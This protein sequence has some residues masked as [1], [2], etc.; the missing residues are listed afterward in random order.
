MTL[1]REFYANAKEHRN[2][3]TK[4]CGIVVRFDEE[5]IN[6]HLGLV[7]PKEDDL[8]N[9][10]KTADMQKVM[11]TI[12]FKRTEWNISNGAHATFDSKYLE[13][14]M[15]VWFNF[16]NARL[17]PTTHVS[18]CSRER[19]L[20]LF[21]IATGMRMN[22][23]AIINAAILH[24]ANINNVAFP[25]PS[26]LT[27]LFEKAGINTADNAICRPI[28]ALDPNGIVRNWNNQS[29]DR[30]DEAEPSRASTRR[31]S[32]ASISDLHE[33]YQHH[34]KRLDDIQAQLAYD[35]QWNLEH[36][37]YQA[38]CFNTMDKMFQHFSF[39]SGQD[40]TGFPQMPPFPD[41]LRQPYQ[42]AS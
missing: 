20:A 42:R 31:K 41:R 33:M 36:A 18:E 16:I 40:M 22:V 28:R 24:A 10:T 27:A 38:S 32:K 19:A 2:H 26:L 37:E 35:R 4:V 13:K 9:Y 23:G 17:Y 15:K 30:E 21:A 39:S 11:D 8:A 14:N 3:K 7:A 6:R 5:T 29:E 25:F 12:C 1:V 34:D